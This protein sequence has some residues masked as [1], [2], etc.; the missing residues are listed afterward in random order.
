MVTPRLPIEAGSIMVF[1]RAIGD[2]NPIYSDPEY[3]RGTEVGGIIAPPT[4]TQ[5]SAHYDPDFPLRPRIGEPWMGSGREP[6]GIQGGGPVGGAP[7]GGTGLHAEQH[8]EYHRP[9]RPGDVLTFETKRGRTWEK[10]GRRA[11]KLTFI[12]TVI[13]YRDEYGE[14]VVTVRNVGVRTERVVDQERG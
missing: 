9:L 13:E 7:G 1:A 2:P 10:E 11:G 8:F 3:A 14:L 6:T 12:E 5:S 4:F